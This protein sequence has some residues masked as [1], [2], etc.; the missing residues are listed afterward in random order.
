MNRSRLITFFITAVTVFSCDN[1][2]TVEPRYANFFIKYHGDNGN[3]IATQFAQTDDGGF[4]VVGTSSEEENPEEAAKGAEIILIK[5]DAEGNEE[6]TFTFGREYDDEGTAVE[7]LAD[8]TGYY[9]AGNSI[10]S[11][12]FK[13]VLVLK[14]SNQGDEENRVILG[15]TGYDHDVNDI[16]LLNENDKH[17]GEI[18]LAGSSTYVDGFSTAKDVTGLVDDYDFYYPKLDVNLSLITE[19]KGYW[20]FEGT[21]RATAIAQNQN[22][23]FII[24]GTSNRKE[25]NDQIK[26]NNNFFLKTFNENELPESVGGGISFGTGDDQLVHDMSSTSDGGQLMVGTTFSG[27]SSN[28]FIARTNSANEG[29][30]TFSITKV[31]NT[32]GKAIVESK[33]GGFLILG[34]IIRN[35]NSDIYL[36]KTNN[37]GAIIWEQVFGGNN[38]DTPGDLLQLEDGSIVFTCTVTLE[39]QQKIGLIKT[40]K[41]GELMN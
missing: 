24:C 12:G 31:E 28:I 37:R 5:T 13:D 10:N 27:N 22:N 26:D 6:W 39:N 40:N 36:V 4:I 14:V 34:S 25:P 18:I 33:G 38:D 7:V 11:T 3:Q 2:K 9:V 16:H 8:G 32:K 35:A 19:W 15:N 29:I 41:N 30:G 21:D 20:G 1:E 23:D 17:G